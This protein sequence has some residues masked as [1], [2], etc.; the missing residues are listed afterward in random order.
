M[1]KLIYVV[2]TSLDG[3]TEDRTGGLDWTDPDEEYF[4]S[5]NALERPIGTYLYGRRM[6]EAMLYWETAPIAGQPSWVAEFTGIWRAADKV[7][8]SKTL[9][10]VSMDRSTL[11][12]DFDVETIRRRKADDTRD[13]AVGGADLAAQALGA[14]LVDECHL[15]I[16]PVVLG[17]GK[18]AFATPDRVELGLLH[19]RRLHS[20][21]V[22]LHYRTIP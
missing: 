15:F 5:I 10:S 18:P 20:G 8:Y 6:Y 22:H 21:V 9:S 17:D 11:E 2:N 14:S 16:W 1:A 19:E 4:G 12:R 7:V 13:L 3:Y